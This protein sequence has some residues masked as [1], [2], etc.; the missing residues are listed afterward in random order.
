M[1][2]KDERGGGND[3]DARAISSQGENPRIHIL[4]SP[5]RVPRGGPPAVK[6][7]RLSM[8]N[9]CASPP[10]KRVDDICSRRLRP[11]A[12]LHI[13]WSIGASHGNWKFE[14]TRTKLALFIIQ[15]PPSQGVTLHVPPLRKTV[16]PPRVYICGGD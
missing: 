2:H 7:D 8:I 10:L 16:G 1:G 5:F 3:A 6:G 14:Q 9:M 12:G 11:T 13:T 4:V 15:V